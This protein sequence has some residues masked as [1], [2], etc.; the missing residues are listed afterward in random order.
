MKMT[1]HCDGGARGNPGPAA[2]AFVV[3]VDSAQVYEEGFYLG[4]NTNNVAEYS[5]AVKAL[6]WLIGYTSIKDI[7][8]LEFVFDS[9]LVVKQITGVYKI[10]SPHLAQLAQRVLALA[11]Q[12]PVTPSYRHVL[13]ADNRDADLLVNQTLD[14]R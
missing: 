6:E 3:S 11:R 4:E 8:S 13:R 10:K 2:C 7:T 12:L 5:A 14:N 9:E 1:I